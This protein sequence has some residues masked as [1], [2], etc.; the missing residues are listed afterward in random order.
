[1]SDD[2]IYTQPTFTER[3]ADSISG[4]GHAA[5][6]HANGGREGRRIRYAVE[7]NLDG[8]EEGEEAALNC[9]LASNLLHERSYILDAMAH[10]VGEVIAER[11]DKIEE[12]ERR[13]ERLAGAVDV[14]RT[15][16]M[17]RV[18]GTYDPDAADSYK[19]FDIVALDGSS[20][21]ALEDRPG[22]CPGE[23]WQLLASAGKRGTR[24][25]PGE[26][27]ERGE[28]G[29]SAPA[30]AAI[31]GLHVNPVTY[32]LTILTGDRKLHQ[33]SLK[34]VFQS[35]FNAIRGEL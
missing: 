23:G 13:V 14:L 1:M 33:L 10:S 2:L 16:R 26:K 7:Y 24:G 8:S 22:P 34:P 18:R 4:N 19:M 30:S 17:M 28:P 9:W 27:G 5:P 31:R 11:D 12:L 29:L 32:M 6:A 21:I 3:A 25:F 35:F 15:G 20:F